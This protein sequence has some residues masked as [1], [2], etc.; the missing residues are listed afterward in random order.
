MNN[1]QEKYKSYKTPF[2]E[3][4]FEH[5]QSIREED[6]PGKRGAWWYFAGIILLFLIP[7]GLF[8]AFLNSNEASV[9]ENVVEVPQ[10]ETMQHSKL[11][12][13]FIEETS[14][15]DDETIIEKEQ[16]TAKTNILNEVIEDKSSSIHR[17]RKGE[18]INTQ[19]NI[20]ANSIGDVR[21]DFLQN[22]HLITENNNALV[23]K[24]D[25]IQNQSLINTTQKIIDAVSPKNIIQKNKKEILFEPEQIAVPT[26]LLNP[27]STDLAPILITDPINPKSYLRN[28]FKLSYNYADFYWNNPFFGGMGYELIDKK[29][30]LIQGEYFRNLNKILSIGTSVGYSRGEDI[31]NQTLDT[32]DFERIIY[33]HLN[34][35][36]FLVNSKKHQLYFKAGTGITNTRL[37]NSFF[38]ITPDMISR[39]IHRTNLTDT[40]LLVEFSY[41]YHFTDRWFGSANFGAITH[42]DGAWYTGLSLG[43]SF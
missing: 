40:G 27:L 21:S 41:S 16:I 3:A 36:L 12:T 28:H 2:D 17:E 43:Y 34:L 10:K 39:G 1:L 8:V 38:I 25:L 6:K 37:L 30:Y 33:A 7:A 18:I 26:Q 35:Y 5:F 13:T 9:A 22:Q 11:K 32:L 19:S 20:K 24:K 15:N 14:K 29:G 23:D 31:N 42:N 4:A